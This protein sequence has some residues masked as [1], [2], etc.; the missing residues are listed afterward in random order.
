MA[1]GTSM[2][3]S[4]VLHTKG[5]KWLVCVTHPQRFPPQTLQHRPAP[6]SAL[7]APGPAASEASTGRIVL[8]LSCMRSVE[9]RLQVG[10]KRKRSFPDSPPPRQQAAPA[11]RCACDHH[12]PRGASPIR[13]HC[14]TAECVAPASRCCCW[15]A[16]KHSPGGR[17]RQTP[18]WHGRHGRVG[19]ACNWLWIQRIVQLVVNVLCGY[20]PTWAGRRS[21]KLATAVYR[22][23]LNRNPGLA[24]IDM[25]EFEVQEQL[26]TLQVGQDGMSTGSD[27]LQRALMKGSC[28]LLIRC[29]RA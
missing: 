27:V 14:C 15:S 5:E 18:L 1:L 17:W 19:T 23:A 24:P 22:S 8:M 21:D 3:L 29:R 6:C 28:L 25:S 26:H 9:S 10:C 12:M 13:C 4:M 16:R 2:P 7:P 20:C 11:R